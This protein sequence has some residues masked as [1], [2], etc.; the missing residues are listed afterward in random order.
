M[1]ETDT[2]LEE[3]SRIFA[4]GDQTKGGLPKKRGSKHPK[5]KK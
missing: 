2:E 5:M 3:N 4:C 1:E